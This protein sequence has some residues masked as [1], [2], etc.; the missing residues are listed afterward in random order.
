MKGSIERVRDPPL[1]PP[2]ASRLSQFATQSETCA[3]FGEDLYVMPF[4]PTFQM[5]KPG[6]VLNFDHK[7]MNFLLRLKGT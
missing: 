6:M 4:F 7:V 3:M 2:D 5:F 1:L